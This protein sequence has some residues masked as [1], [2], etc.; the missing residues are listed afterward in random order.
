[1]KFDSLSAED[2]I[3]K[4]PVTGEIASIAKKGMTTSCNH[5][6]FCRE[7]TRTQITGFT[8]KMLM[9][10][11]CTQKKPAINEGATGQ[12]RLLFAQHRINRV[13]C[14]FCST[15]CLDYRSR[16][17]CNISACKHFSHRGTELIIDNHV[18]P[19]PA[20]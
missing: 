4:R 5:Q 10:A 8:G 13:C 17:G 20:F 18:T 19:L 16:T 14:T 6:I 12:Y 1:M 2:A 3:I 7:I 11:G 9:T 15:H